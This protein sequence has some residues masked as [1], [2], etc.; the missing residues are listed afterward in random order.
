MAHFCKPKKYRAAFT[1]VELVITIA[2]FLL[3]AGLTTTFISFMGG[4]SSTREEQSA[5]AAH[6]AAVREE[7]DYWFSYFDRGGCTVQVFPRAFEGEGDGSGSR[8]IAQAADA[9]VVYR[10]RLGV[11][12]AE[13]A[14]ET[15]RALIAEYPLSA[16][17]GAAAQGAAYKT[18]QVGCGTVARIVFQEYSQNNAPVYAENASSEALRFTVYANVNDWAFACTVYYDTEG[19]Q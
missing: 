10:L 14:G 12:A 9:G 8:V 17:H 3:V 16:Q 13:G 15:E 1:L 19:G 11:F 5:R 7:I 4:F 18:M 2:L 6:T